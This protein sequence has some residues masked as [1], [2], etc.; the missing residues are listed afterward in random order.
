MF[1]KRRNLRVL[2]EFLSEWRPLADSRVERY[3]GLRKAMYLIDKFECKLSLQAWKKDVVRS[4]RLDVESK[5]HYIGLIHRMLRPCFG[6]LKTYRLRKQAGKARLLSVMTYVKQKRIVRTFNQLK[7]N[8]R[9]EKEDRQNMEKAG[10]FRGLSLYQRALYMLAE[11][12][13]F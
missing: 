5:S 3:A 11:N 4:R 6:V 9:V 2:Q 10:R 13:R 7:W 1:I 12:K 8:A